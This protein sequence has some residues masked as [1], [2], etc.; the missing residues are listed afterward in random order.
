MSHVS[1]QDLGIPEAYRLESFHYVPSGNIGVAVFYRQAKPSVNR[2]FWRRSNDPAYSLIPVREDNYSLD[3]CFPAPA[4][5][6]LYYL[7]MEW[8]KIGPEPH[9]VGG[10]WVS[11]N[12]FNFEF[13]REETLLTQN[14]FIA[15]TGSEDSWICKIAH[16]S[17]D[18]NEIDVIA[19]ISDPIGDSESETKM[20]YAVHRIRLAEKNISCRFPLPAVFI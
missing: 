10:Y 13:G 2:I 9:E 11:L 3:S 7:V 20:K 8:R 1:Y 14:D 12:R 4:S 15:L 16:I 17:P 18:E 6:N 19:G 5:C